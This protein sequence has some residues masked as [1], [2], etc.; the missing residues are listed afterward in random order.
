MKKK[1]FG[2]EQMKIWHPL[3]STCGLYLLSTTSFRPPKSF[4]P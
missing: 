1:R 3:W 2:M 4:S